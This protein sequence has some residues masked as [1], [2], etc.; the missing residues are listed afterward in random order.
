MK[1]WIKIISVLHIIGGIFGIAF[2]GWLV[3]TNLA[4]T[5]IIMIAIIGVGIYTLSLVAGISLWRGRTFGRTASIIVQAIQLLKIISPSIIFTFS[6]GLDIWVHFLLAGD[7]SNVG[8]NFRFLAYNEL[9]F[10]VQD[11]P[12]G[13]GISIISCVFLPILISYRPHTTVE[14]ALPPPPPVEW[15]NKDLT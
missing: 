14:E 3:L 4:N 6:F 8:L 11:A 12:S 2:M 10:N 7:L 5:F 15:D 9:Y 1:V 13:F